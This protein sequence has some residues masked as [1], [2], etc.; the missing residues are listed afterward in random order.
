MHNLYF[1]AQKYSTLHRNLAVSNLRSQYLNER[2][3]AD[4]EKLALIYWGIVSHLLIN[5]HRVDNNRAQQISG[6]LDSCTK[7]WYKQEENYDI[8]C[9]T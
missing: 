4:S 9:N 2:I 3:V 8:W 7:Q 6:M 5:G 1:Y